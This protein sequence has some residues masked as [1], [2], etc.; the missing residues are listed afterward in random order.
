MSM[1]RRNSMRGRKIRRRSNVFSRRAR[2]NAILKRVALA[3]LLVLL[4]PAGFFAA[5]Y[6]MEDAARLAGES[7]A[8]ASSAA[9]SAPGTSSGESSAPEPSEPASGDVSG[10]ALRGVYLP[11]S[12]LSDGA[13][14][15]KVKSAGFNAVVFDLKDAGGALYYASA[16]PMAQQ[17]GAIASDALTVDALKQVR[18]ALSERGLQAV[19]RLYAFKDPLS[20]FGLSSAKITLQGSPGYTWLDNSKEKGGKPWLNPYS[21]DAHS[22]LTGLAGELS[23]MGFTALMLDGVQFPNQTSRADYG[24][25]ELSSLSQSEVLKKFVAEFEDAAGDTC[26]VIQSVPGLAA[27]GDGTTPFGGNPVTFGAQTVS[28]QL[29]PSALGENLKS[30]ET[31][32]PDPAAQPSEAVRLAAGQIQLRLELIAAADRPSLSP[33]LQAEEYTAVQVKEQVAA[34]KQALGNDASYILYRADGQYD[35]SALAEG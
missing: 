12:L 16:T 15:D 35:F 24:S 34:L 13:T 6:M 17:S 32:L 20:P 19:P 4:V 10:G 30:G 23:G 9:S 28:P 21:P 31:L 11:L 5:K 33:W 27:V 3:G 26:R 18:E 8:P 29:F 25:S 1:R 22:Y 7:S 14:L 2:R